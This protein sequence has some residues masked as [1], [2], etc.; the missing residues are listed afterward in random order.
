MIAEEPPYEYCALRFVIQWER[1][2]RS[3][4]EG[5][6]RKLS[7]E[8]IRKALSYFQVARGFARLNE[9]AEFVEKA[10]IETGKRLNE[11]NVIAR[12]TTLTNY[13][14][15]E[16][17]KNNLSAASKLLWLRCRNPVVILDSRAVA[18]LKKLDY[19]VKV[20]DYESFYRAWRQEYD[21]RR[22]ELQRAAK[23]LKELKSCTASW[24]RSSDEF[25]TVIT[26]DWFSERTFDLF[27]WEL[28][29]KS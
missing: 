22:L 3:L 29:G 17:N 19:R 11:G 21:K 9:K 18:A 27:L 7:A 25:R 10:L 26:S 20:G 23:S 24:R 1:D 4:H 16:F 6:A 12:V 28:G 13:F 2:E 5:I 15:Q 8:A 14:F